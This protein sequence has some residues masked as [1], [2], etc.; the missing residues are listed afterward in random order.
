MGGNMPAVA[1][2]GDSYDCGDIQAV[3]SGDVFINNIPVARLGDTTTGHGPPPCFW[4]SRP[5]AQGSGNVFVNSLPIT[6]VGDDGIVHCCGLSC[7]TGA[8]STGSPDVFA[9]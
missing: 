8:L 7:H 6:R 5:V 2:I 1:R 4:P 3:G 9:N